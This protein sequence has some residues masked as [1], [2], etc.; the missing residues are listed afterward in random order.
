MAVAVHSYSCVCVAGFANGWC[1]YDHLETYAEQC[2]ERLGG[3]CDI[4][5]DECASNPCQNGATC[6]ESSVDATISIDEYMCTCMPGFANGMCHYLYVLDYAVQCS[7]VAGGF[8]DVD[9]DECASRPCQNGATCT[10]SSADGRISPHAYQCTCTEGYSNGL[11]DYNFIDEYQALCRVMESDAT[12]SPLANIG[13][14]DVDVDE[15]ASAPC[16][17]GAV[18]LHSSTAAEDVSVHSYRCLCQP[19]YANG[20]CDYSFI[21]EYEPQ[22]SIMESTSPLLL[23][24]GNCH[25]D[26]DECESSP[27]ANGA[28]CSDRGSVDSFSC[29]CLA[30]FDGLV[31][32]IDIAECASAPCKHGATCADDS[33]ADEYSCECVPGWSGYNCETDIDECAST[34][35]RHPAPCSDG[36]DFYRCG[37]PLQVQLVLEMSFEQFDEAFETSFRQEV[38]D[39][40]GVDISRVKVVGLA[41]GSLVVD[42][43]ILPPASPEEAGLEDAASAWQTIFVDGGGGG[44]DIGG[45]PVAAGEVITAESSLGCPPGYDG[46]DC[47]IN[48][49]DCASEP[50][51]HL[52]ACV[53]GVAEYSCSCQV[54]WSGDN[55]EQ[56]LTME[57]DHI[58][59]LSGGVIGADIAVVVGTSILLYARMNRMYVDLSTE[60][61]SY[62]LH[63]VASTLALGS[64]TIATVI[65]AS[66]VRP[67]TA[68][69]YSHLRIMAPLGDSSLAGLALPC[70]A[71]AN[72]EYGGC[73]CATGYSPTSA[74]GLELC[75]TDPGRCDNETFYYCSAVVWEGSSPQSLA[76][77][78]YDSCDGTCARGESS[79][80]A[81][82][83]L[84]A[85]YLVVFC[86]EWA[87]VVANVGSHLHRLPVCLPMWEWRFPPSFL[88]YVA[89][90]A[91]SVVLHAA[92]AI[93]LSSLSG[94][95][96]ELLTAN[97][98]NSDAIFALGMIE[99]RLGMAFGTCVVNMLLGIINLG[100]VWAGVLAYRRSKLIAVSSSSK[101][102]EPARP[103]EAARDE[104]ALIEAGMGGDD[105][106]RFRPQAHRSFLVGSANADDDDEG[107]RDDEDDDGSPLT[108]TTASP[109][110]ETSFGEFSQWSRRE[111]RRAPLP[112]M[113]EG[114]RS[115]PSAASTASSARS[116]NRSPRIVQGLSLADSVRARTSLGRAAAQLQKARESSPAG[117]GRRKRAGGGG[118]PVPA[119]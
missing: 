37:A 77:D 35:C 82:L 14:C 87:A 49:D 34:P 38:A 78:L 41:E 63:A 39:R 104:R 118:V 50:C 31:C 103:K 18:C 69:F 59:L 68:G 11:C 56:Q 95:F 108:A 90:K 47:S 51:Q 99:Q 57:A 19:G 62:S 22:C 60:H 93:F 80:H 71:R 61:F 53:D 111:R 107:Q 101:Y 44:V 28:A 25:V 43:Q 21:D 98:F 102:L 79:G 72:E 113:V 17:N 84:L 83:A 2:S 109:T 100:V 42:V 12:A 33:S 75:I 10:E 1:D 81:V 40:L 52:G 48:L 58:Q 32:S 115:S 36:I 20:K 89:L 30:G 74:P 96:A 54:G 24:A 85:L 110:D 9:V 70:P 7:R 106:A 27:C 88:V 116:S 23:D 29:S 92:T 119:Y 13:N 64:A 65:F 112:G 73:Q 16:R 97:C 117:A 8:C 94:S 45:V 91:I 66:Y 6:T 5:V 76:I 114:G 4:D 86:F 15:C 105:V 55:C 46:L 3:H 26:V 67:A